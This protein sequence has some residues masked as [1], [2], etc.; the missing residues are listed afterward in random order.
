MINPA[1]SRIDSATILLSLLVILCRVSSV[2]A[3]ATPHKVVI[4]HAGMNA[5]TVAL[6][7]AQEQKFFA[8]YGTDA[9]LIFIRQ[10]PILVAGMSAGDVQI[11]A[12]GGTAA[13]LAASGG[14]D[15]KVVASTNG[16]VTYDLVGAPSVKTLKDL[17]GKRFGLQGYGGTLWMALMLGFE[18]LGVNPQE[19]NFQVIG[20]QTVLAQA[21]EA[22]RIDATGLDPV[23]SRRLKQKGFTILSELYKANLP[24][25]GSGIVVT[26][27]FA[28]D[29]PE[30]VENILKA[31]VE[32]IVF[33][34]SPKNRP[35]VVNTIKTRLRI[36][37]TAA[38]EEAYQ[39]VLRSLE[40]NP[41]PALEGMRNIHRLLRMHNPNIDKIK[42]EQLIDD[43][44]MR[45]LDDSGFLS[46]MYNAYGLK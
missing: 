33:S 27:S 26:S 6:W 37:D 46:R 2:T 32:G 16:R 20:D 17:R 34:L 1:R 36:A 44:F 11:A 41:T 4:A 8:K 13:L 5:R 24:F 28:R 43:R 19:L 23:F 15:L 45:K 21:L 3:A 10:A 35:I 14:M 30:T 29:Q 40:K 12:T 39:D 38:A 9:E 18:H 7:T 31:V 22:G 25:I 42:P